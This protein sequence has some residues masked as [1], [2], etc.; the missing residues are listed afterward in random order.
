MTLNKKTL[1]W[2]CVFA[3]LST[4]S[5]IG[6]C[7]YRAQKNAEIAL[8][9]QVKAEAEKKA[10][11]EQAA[12]EANEAEKKAATFFAPASTKGFRFDK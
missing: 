4:A 8:A 2:V 6:V 9:A 12:K 3:T 10:A 5:T 1:V 7:V 11:A